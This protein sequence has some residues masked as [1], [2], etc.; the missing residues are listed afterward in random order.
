VQLD[1]PVAT[2]QPNPIKPDGT[3]S[4]LTVGNDEPFP[5]EKLRALYGDQAGYLERF[6]H[7][8]D[9][10]IGEGWLLGDDADAMR[11]EAEQVDF[12]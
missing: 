2:Y 9:E 5:A 8:L 12:S 6:H 11:R 1:V 4:Y 7:R 3:P 10:L